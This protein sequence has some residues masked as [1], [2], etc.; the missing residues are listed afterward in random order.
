V[1]EDQSEKQKSQKSVLPTSDS[2]KG[3]LSKTERGVAEK[4]RHGPKVSRDSRS[5]STQGPTRYFSAN[6]KGEKE[7]NTGNSPHGQ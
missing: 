1:P 7:H 3:I 5:S 2:G 6:R 4:N